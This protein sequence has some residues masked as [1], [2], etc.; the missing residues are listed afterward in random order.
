[1]SLPGN[2]T[3]ATAIQ[4]SIEAFV[5]EIAEDVDLIGGLSGFGVAPTGYGLS[6]AGQ[7]VAVNKAMFVDM[8][9]K[10]RVIPPNEQMARDVFVT[11]FGHEPDQLPPLLAE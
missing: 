9:R 11:I 6:N 2:L 7:A 10:G 5:K 1:M 4:D 3:L 8:P